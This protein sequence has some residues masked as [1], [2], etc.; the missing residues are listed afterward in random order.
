MSN[1][2]KCSDRMPP[3]VAGSSV[4]Y[5]VYET[6]NNRVQHDYLMVLADEGVTSAIWNHY[7][8]YVT[9]WQPLPAPPE[10]V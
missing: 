6:L 1:W 7:D 9:H 8:G 2:I 4:E 10:D 3:K 5:L